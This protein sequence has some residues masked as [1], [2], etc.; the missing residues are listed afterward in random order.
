MLFKIVIY[1]PCKQETK[2]SDSF[3]TYF[4]KLDYL[5]IDEA[6]RQLLDGFEKSLNLLLTLP[7]IPPLHE[8]TT[9]MTSATMSCEG[10]H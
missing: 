3:K 4:S 5:V 1:A 10:M 2:W 8:R 7:D 9:V 6:D